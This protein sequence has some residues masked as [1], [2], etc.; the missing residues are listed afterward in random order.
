MAIL[1]IPLAV[2][3]LAKPLLMC[4]DRER[5]ACTYTQI[6]FD[7]VADWEEPNGFSAGMDFI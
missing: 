1:P 5:R 4:F 6:A 2:P 7:P 3:W